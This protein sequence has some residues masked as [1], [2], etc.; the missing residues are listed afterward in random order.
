MREF[1]IVQLVKF[2][3]LVVAVLGLAARDFQFDDVEGTGFLSEGVG[4]REVLA[5]QATDLL[6]LFRLA[7]SHVENPVLFGVGVLRNTLGD[8]PREL[9]AFYV[10]VVFSVL[11]G[12]SAVALQ[13]I[14]ST[15]K[16]V[17]A[18]KR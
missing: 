8:C 15:L 3:S 2:L 14:I 1:S 5:I 13:T 18:Q 9:G 16:E 11:K 4:L 7:C 6:I 10:F 12:I 17:V